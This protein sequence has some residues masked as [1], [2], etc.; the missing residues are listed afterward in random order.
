MPD[1]RSSTSV[2][3]A[4][5]GELLIVKVLGINGSPRIGGNTDILL[6]R[7]LEGAGNKGAETEKIILNNILSCPC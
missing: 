3:R 1:L 6:D 4:D 5:R 7:V 2:L